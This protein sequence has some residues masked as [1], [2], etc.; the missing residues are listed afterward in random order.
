MSTDSPHG[1]E[2]SGNGHAGH[3]FAGATKAVQEVAAKNP[4]FYF[5]ERTGNY[6]LEYKTCFF[7]VTGEQLKHHLALNGLHVRKE[8]DNGLKDGDRALTICRLER[9]VQ[10]AGAL[11]GHPVGIYRTRAG[12]LAL[13][14]TEARPVPARA[15]DCEV[16]ETFLTQ[17]LVNQAEYALYWLK[18]ARQT[19]IDR[20]FRP[21]QMLTLAGPPSCGKSLF[22]DLITSFLGGRSARPYRYMLGLT[23]FN[24]DLAAAEHLVIADEPSSSMDIRARRSFGEALKD[25]AVNSEISIHAKGKN[26]ELPVPTFRR[27]SMSVN[28]EPENLAKLPPMDESILDKIVLL[29]CSPAQVDADRKKAWETLTSQLP[30]LAWNLEKMRIPKP[31]LCPRFG[32]LAY[33]NP[34][35]FEVVSEISPETR[36]LNLINSVLFSQLPGESPSHWRKRQEDEPEFKGQAI[37]LERRLRASSFSFAVEKLLSFPGAC[38]TYLAR[39]ASKFPTRFSKA[40]SRGENLWT[41]KAAEQE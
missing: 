29:K 17:L 5:D 3:E 13:V 14:T 8:D 10:Y 37:E 22:Q 32:F 2:G 18:V 6:Q 20:S 25:L 33:Q 36:L 26:A 1:K 9:R 12:T 24:A 16:L 35:L 39:L 40:R 7:G 15:G 21:G 4:A 27:I 38:G 34:E 31:K 28:S 19:M 30:A 41:I 11:A 23:Q